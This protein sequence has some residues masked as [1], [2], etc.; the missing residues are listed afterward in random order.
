MPNKQVAAEIGGLEV[1]G[2]GVRE[3]G[4]GRCETLRGCERRSRRVTTDA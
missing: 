2:L 3:R 4:P 1:E